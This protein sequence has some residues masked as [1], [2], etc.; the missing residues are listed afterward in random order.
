M[1][2]NYSIVTVHHTIILKFEMVFPV[3]FLE[4]LSDQNV[5]SY[6]IEIITLKIV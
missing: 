3:D 6:Y 2:L 4:G 1:A 5:K